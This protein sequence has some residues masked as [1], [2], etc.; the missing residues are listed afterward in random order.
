MEDHAL[1]VE[2][3][4]TA[5]MGVLL[6]GLAVYAVFGATTVVAIAF[7]AR[8]IHPQVASSGATTFAFD[9]GL[10]ALFGL[11]HSIMA[12]EEFKQWWSRTIPEAIQR[13][14]YVLLASL[15]LLIMFWQWR[16]VDTTAW[17]VTGF[18]R[19]LLWAVFGIGWVT[20]IYS[21]FLID[22]FDLVGLRQTWNF[23]RDEKPESIDFRTPMLYRLV[24]HPM[25][26]G[27][28][29]LFWANPTM[30]LDMVVLAV[31]ITVYILIGLRFEEK[32]LLRWYGQQYHAY[33]RRTPMLIPFPLRLP[34]RD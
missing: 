10:F 11:Q 6:F 3:S 27:F 21:T 5:R 8:A 26:V 14:I 20:V 28:V 16:A 23:F 32:D 24:R 17:H 33:R 18:P 34:R 31:A 15:L 2:T 4:R 1:Q 30:T 12:R 25:M 19:L 13:S 9:L 7:T 22:H 29:L